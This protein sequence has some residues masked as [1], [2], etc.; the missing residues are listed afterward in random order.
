M[1][2]VS[3]IIDTIT[4]VNT[5]SSGL[6]SG[7]NSDPVYTKTALIDAFVNND[8][9]KSKWHNTTRARTPTMMKSSI[10]PKF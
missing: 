6:N 1:K 2:R 10:D 7:L 5:G 3:E 4:V 9:T 8:L